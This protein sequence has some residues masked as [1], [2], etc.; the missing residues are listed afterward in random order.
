MHRLCDGRPLSRDGGGGYISTVK[1]RDSK[2]ANKQKI[3]LYIFSS[4]FHLFN[5]FHILIASVSSQAA[6]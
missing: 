3:Y 6:A 4:H 2:Y 1:Y 5:Q